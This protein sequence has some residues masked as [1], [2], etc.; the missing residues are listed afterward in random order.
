[1][2]QSHITRCSSTRL[3]VRAESAP[4]KYSVT[5]STKCWQLTSSTG[6]SNSLGEWPLL[7]GAE[8]C[9]CLTLPACP[10]VTRPRRRDPPREPPSVVSVHDVTAPAASPG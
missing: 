10:F 3:R 4:S 5:S 8:L 6:R 1:M 7:G 9:T 2:H